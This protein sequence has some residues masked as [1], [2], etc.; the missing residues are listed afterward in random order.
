MEGIAITVGGRRYRVQCAPEEVDRLQGL[1]RHVDARASQITRSQGH[2]QET[3]LLLLVCLT[4]A[5]ELDDATN[6]VARLNGQASEIE[7]TAAARG[8]AV[9]ERAAA[10]LAGM[11]DRIDRQA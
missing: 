11:A 6:E 8:V 7:A 4:L 1:A 3:M 5:D 9:L 2:I 10:R